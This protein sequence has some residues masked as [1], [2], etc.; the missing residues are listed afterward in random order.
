MKYKRTDMT[1]YVE[2]D[3]GQRKAAVLVL[4]NAGLTQ[5]C[6]YCHQGVIERNG[7]IRDQCKI[8]KRKVVKLPLGP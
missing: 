4:R 7:V 5:V 1:V 3:Y 6:P 2:G 8:C